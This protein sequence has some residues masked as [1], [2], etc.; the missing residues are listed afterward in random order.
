MV[1]IFRPTAN[2]AAEENLCRLKKLLGLDLHVN[3]FKVVHGKFALDNKEIA[4]LNRSMMQ[5]MTAYASCI[6]TQVSDFNEI[7]MGSD[8][9]AGGSKKIPAQ[10][11]IHAHNGTTSPDDAFVSVHYRDRWCW[12]DDRDDDS[13]FMFNLLIVLFSFKERGSPD[14]FTPVITVPAN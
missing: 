13:K 8:G 14:A 10:P 11:L 12:I 7:P 6:D 9:Q 2:A 1:I 3:E 5:I 4:V